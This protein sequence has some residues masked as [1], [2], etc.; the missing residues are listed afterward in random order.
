MP[1]KR[2]LR[3][4]LLSAFGLATLIVVAA[5]PLAATTTA[6]ETRPAARAAPSARANLDPPTNLQIRWYSYSQSNGNC[7]GKIDPVSAIFYGTHDWSNV[8]DELSEVAG[9]DPVLIQAS[10]WFWMKDPNTFG[11][12]CYEERSESADG[13]FYNDRYHIR[14][15]ECYS[16]YPVNRYCDDQAEPFVFGT[17]HYETVHTCGHVVDPTVD[18][19]SGY[20]QGRKRLHETWDADEHF[21]NSKRYVGNTHPHRGCQ[22]IN[23]LWYAASNGWVRFFDMSTD[24]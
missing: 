24:P 17:P 3:G 19:W 7:P 13:S 22:A 20:D 9:W 15:I 23:G 14:Y 21:S 2:D 16:D 6:A 18:G 11:W 12:V 4:W 5:F 1:Y 8:A 10:Q